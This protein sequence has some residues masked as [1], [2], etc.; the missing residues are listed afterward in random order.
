MSIVV[1]ANQRVH[2]ALADCYNETEPHFRPENKQKVR[3][4]LERARASAPSAARLLDLGCGT[5][6]ILDLA[7]DLF[8]AIDGIDATQAMLDRVDLSPG[9]IRLHRGVVESLPFD[10]GTFD[11]V[12]AY[13]FLDHLEDPYAVLSEARR[14]L[15]RGGQLYVDLI[16]NHAF[17]ASVEAAATS[18]ERPLGPTVEREIEELLLHEEK[19]EK[20]FGI[21]PEDWRN[22][23]PAKS[24]GKGFVSAEL[25]RRVAELGFEAKVEAEWFLGQA[26]V[27]HGISASS[28]LEMDLHLRSL[29]PVTLGLYKYLV[30]TAT[31]R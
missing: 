11:V 10:D 13:S 24:E 22:A 9:N 17:W 26:V 23:E 31:K 25:A 3:G 15:K 7:H 21:A 29:L 5:G 27:H 30:L 2:S 20:A 19:L 16:P 18:P 12:T 8:E 4:R 14:V 28:A 6:F 1:E